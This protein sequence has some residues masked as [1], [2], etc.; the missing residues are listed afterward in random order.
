MTS[1]YNELEK[2]TSGICALTLQTNVFRQTKENNIQKRC[3]H[4]LRT[5]I[6]LIKIFSDLIK[7]T[8]SNTFSPTTEAIQ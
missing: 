2:T 3:L 5:Y 4:P 6:Y 7:L 8:V 1:V